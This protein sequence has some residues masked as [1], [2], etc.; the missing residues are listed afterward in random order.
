MP[1]NQTGF[2][3]LPRYGVAGIAEQEIRM[4]KTIPASVAATALVTGIAAASAAEPGEDA[5]FQERG[6]FNAA[7]MRG[8]APDL[9]GWPQYGLPAETCLSA[10]RTRLRARV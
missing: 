4:R 3:A 8:P 6:N 2:P 7:L 9:N 1:Q 5:Y 10:G